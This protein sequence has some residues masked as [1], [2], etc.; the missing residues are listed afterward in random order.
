[1]NHENHDEIESDP[2]DS[3]TELVPVL[4]PLSIHERGLRELFADAH[5][6]WLMKSPSL[7]TRRNYVRDVGQFIQFVGSPPDHLEALASVRPH[8]VA[9]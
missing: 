2:P 4:P 9:A 1:M 5:R 7:D 8:D 3:T 6:S